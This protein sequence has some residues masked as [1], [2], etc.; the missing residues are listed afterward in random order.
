MHMQGAACSDI[1]ACGA[2]GCTC[3]QAGP[4]RCEGACHCDAPD[5][6]RVTN[7]H[8]TLQNYPQ[9][10][11]GGNL[12]AA[13]TESMLGPGAERRLLLCPV[14]PRRGAM[15]S[16]QLLALPFATQ[17][18]R[19]ATLHCQ[20][21][22]VTRVDCHT[23]PAATRLN[24]AWPGSAAV[25]AARPAALLEN[26]AVSTP[27]IGDTAADGAGVMWL[28]ATPGLSAQSAEPTVCI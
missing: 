18:C 6:L 23:P 8:T 28:R 13:Q 22:L 16:V 20:A 26:V 9:G 1:S 4:P 2:A 17:T 3:T 10:S 5:L 7:L 27:I 12:H 19:T 11:Q 25:A 14:C 24:R 21:E 15:P